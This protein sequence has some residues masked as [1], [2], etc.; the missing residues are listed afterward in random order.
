MWIVIALAIAYVFPGMTEYGPWKP[1]E[2]YVFGMVHS[3]MQ[4]G[5]W[6]VPTLAGEPFMEKPP[7]YV[8]VAAF[9]A[10]L[11]SPWISAEHGARLAIG[12]FMLVTLVCLGLAARRWWGRGQGRMAALAALGSIGLA[13]HG[14]MMIPDLPLL[15]GFAVAL[16]GFAWINEHPRKGGLLLGTGIGMA[17]MGKGVLGLAGIGATALVLPMLFGNWRTVTYRRGLIYAAAASAPWLL[18][19]PAALYFRSPALFMEWFWLN[20]IGRFLGFSV[21]ALGAAHDPGF[22]PSTVPWFTFPALPLAGCALWNKRKILMSS[23]ACQVNVTMFAI[24][25]ATLSVSASAR[26]VYLLPLLAPLAIIAAPGAMM[27]TTRFDIA[28]DWVARVL[29]G[30]LVVLVWGVAIWFAMSGRPPEWSLLNRHLP[31]DFSF[32]LRPHQV[33]AAIGLLAAWIFIMPRAVA[34]RG[35]GLLS[36]TSGITV[37]WGTLFAL[38]LPWIDAAKSYQATF[39]ELNES[40]P[41]NAGCVAS[42]GLGESERGMLHYVTGIISKRLEVAPEPDCDVLLRQGI[43]SEPPRH[44]A[45]EGW[46]LLWEGSRPGE[47]RERFWL[48][49][50]RSDVAATLPQAQTPRV[51][52]GGL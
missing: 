27:L 11:S 52:A 10:T 22:M 6:V 5:D 12:V 28:A 47:Q 35:R 21:A 8:W 51:G 49:V 44:L 17:F 1:D 33:V 14:H 13:Q 15:A 34:M 43:S 41:L 3:L 9:T 19:W 38:L 36:W 39:S 45:E 18:I 42:M 7:L 2:P 46:H 30:S 4:S 40:I 48:F 50:R 31:M 24:M 37:L 26:A 25:V 23:P 16:L 32:E 29:F 20:N